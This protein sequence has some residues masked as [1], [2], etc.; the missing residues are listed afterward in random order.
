MAAECDAI[1]EGKLYV[2]NYAAAQDAALLDRHNVT[3]VLSAGFRAGHFS[4]SSAPAA[5]CYRYH[6][7]DVRDFPN[8]NLLRHLPRATNFIQ[9]AIDG[10]DGGFCVFVHCIH[11]QSRSCA[12]V[13]AYLMRICWESSEDNDDDPKSLLHR[14]YQQVETARP[15]MAINPGFVRQLEMYRRMICCTSGRSPSLLTPPMS[16]AHAAFRSFRARSEYEESGRISKWFPLS[17]ADGSGAVHETCKCSKCRQVLFFRENI[18]E[19]LTKEDESALPK[20]DYWAESAGGLEYSRAGQS[21]VSGC[22]C[23]RNRV[24]L[25]DLSVSL[26]VETMDWMQSQMEAKRSGKLTCPHCSSKVGSWDWGSADIWSS[27][28]ITPG[29]VE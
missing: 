2:G 10:G 28:F 15:C 14:C 22:L 1:L 6:C 19:E 24:I 11:G 21:V 5:K 16:T 23:G 4:S 17:S 20:S 18:I 27:I 12:I 25:A 3:H 9:K 29:K 26:K 13:V 8:E 7:V